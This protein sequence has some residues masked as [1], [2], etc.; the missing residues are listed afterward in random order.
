MGDA[1][2]YCLVQDGALTRYRDPDS[3][4][5]CV[6][7]EGTTIRVVTVKDVEG[8]LRGKVQHGDDMGW[9]TLRDDVFEV[10]AKPINETE[11]MEKDKEDL[12]VR[13]ADYN[14]IGG[15]TIQSDY[16]LPDIPNPPPT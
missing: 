5:L 2:K 14:E 11:E 8:T 9:L 6:I 15:N 10:F 3:E 13:L 1:G 7:A 16:S 4:E 12:K